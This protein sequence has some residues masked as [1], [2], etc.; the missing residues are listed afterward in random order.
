[1]EVTVKSRFKVSASGTLRNPEKDDI[2]STVRRSTRVIRFSLRGSTR[3]VGVVL[4]LGNRQ[5][6]EVA[7]MGEHC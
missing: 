3:K 4:E 6:G 2:Q 1:M 7:R 5:P